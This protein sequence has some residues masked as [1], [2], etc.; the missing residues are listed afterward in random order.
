MSNEEK[1]YKVVTEE[2]LYS[3]ARIITSKVIAYTSAQ[4]QDIYQEACILLLNRIGKHF[5]HT[6]DWV[7]VDVA[8]KFYGRKELLGEEMYERRNFLM[9]SSFDH[10]QFD[11]D[12]YYN[13][14]FPD[15]SYDYIY[16]KLQDFVSDFD[17]KYDYKDILFALSNSDNEVP[18][19]YLMRKFNI[20]DVNAQQI[21]CQFRK[22]I[23]K[24][25][26]MNE[27]LNA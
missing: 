9:N 13:H 25:F 19:K 11:V 12:K 24:N 18:Y 8:R 16:K 21:I 2:N 14:Y 23:R 10:T 4:K 3:A 5:E 1:N 27:L 6:I 7:T 15:D 17:T 26:D 22:C 20:T